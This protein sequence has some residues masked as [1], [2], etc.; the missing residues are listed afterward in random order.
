[1]EGQGVNLTSK[2]PLQEFFS[3]YTFGM[4]ATLKNIVWKNKKAKMNFVEKYF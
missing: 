2:P 1:M 3:G 4:Q